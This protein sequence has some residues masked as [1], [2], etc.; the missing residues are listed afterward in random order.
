M[1]GANIIVVSTL[2]LHSQTLFTLWM[3]PTDN[4]N[5]ASGKEEDEDDENDDDDDLPRISWIAGGPKSLLPLQV[6]LLYE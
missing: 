4:A 5:G 3:H 2:K 6:S 1:L